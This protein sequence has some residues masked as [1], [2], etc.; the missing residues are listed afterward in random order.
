[1]F[2]ANKYFTVVIN[3]HNGS[4]KSVLISIIILQMKVQVCKGDITSHS[5]KQNK[6]QPWDAGPTPLIQPLRSAF[7][8]L[9]S[10]EMPRDPVK[11][12]TICRLTS[13]MIPKGFLV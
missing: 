10:E 4:T 13:E 5:Q 3:S 11:T 7:T 12:G 6:G 8:P 2:Y 9:V 1:M